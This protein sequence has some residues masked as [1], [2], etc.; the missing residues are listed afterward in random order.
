MALSSNLQSVR[1]VSYLKTKIDAVV[2][3]GTPS[4]KMLNQWNRNPKIVKI[5]YELESPIHSQPTVELDNRINWTANYRRESTIVTPYEKFVPFDYAE[6]QNKTK[7]NHAATKT[8]MVA[9]FV[10]NCRD[11]NGRLN[12]AKELGKHVQVDIYG[13]CGNL[14]CPR[15]Y[16]KDCFTM[17]DKDYKFYLSFENSACRDYI[18][19]KLFWNALQ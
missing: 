9:W 11:K 2:F 1:E 12:Y 19:E 10:S 13:A 15:R 7:I 4:R 6:T 3:K 18:T 17:L 14:S 8:K 5:W 16:A